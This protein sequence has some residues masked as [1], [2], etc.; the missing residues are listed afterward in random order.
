ME[1][2][3]EYIRIIH[4]HEKVVF[5]A[6]AGGV[7]DL[8]WYLERYFESE[9]L[10]DGYDLHLDPGL[11][12]D[13]GS[14]SLIFQHVAEFESEPDGCESTIFLRVTVTGATILIQSTVSGFAKLKSIAAQI[15]SE[16]PNIVPREFIPG[17]TLTRDSLPFGIRRC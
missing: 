16:L 10:R 14:C 11:T 8:I 2:T 3:D 1:S 7:S 12:L 13:P 15:Q 5:C 9:E 17:I 6:T 4:V